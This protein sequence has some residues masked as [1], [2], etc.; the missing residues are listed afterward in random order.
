VEA[1]KE[2][3]GVASRMLIAKILDPDDY[4]RLSESSMKEVAKTLSEK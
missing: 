3:V 1:R 2:L 4:R